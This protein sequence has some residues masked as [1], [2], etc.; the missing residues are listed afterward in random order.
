MRAS[1]SQATSE[2]TPTDSPLETLVDLHQAPTLFSVVVE[3]LVVLGKGEE[4]VGPLPRQLR[5]RQIQQ[6]TGE[7]GKNAKT[8]SNKNI[9][10]ESPPAMTYVLHNGGRGRGED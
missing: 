8:Y 5:A 7:A 3:H 6:H 4:P 2:Q 9:R 1:S 10:D